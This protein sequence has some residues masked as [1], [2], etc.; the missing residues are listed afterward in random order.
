MFPVP[1]GMDRTASR[2]PRARSCVP[3]AHGDRPVAYGGRGSAKSCS[4]CPRGWTVVGRLVAAHDRVFPVPTG[5]DRSGRACRPTGASCPRAHG[6]GL[7]GWQYC[8]PPG[9]SSLCSR[10]WTAARPQPVRHHESVPR[11][12]GDGPELPDGPPATR[13]AS[14]L[15]PTKYNTRP[16]LNR[17]R[18]RAGQAS[19]MTQPATASRQTFMTTIVPS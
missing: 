9:H 13:T 17:Q 12:H 14:F 16:S 8:H 11:V 2:R 18:R 19:D 3:R 4:P 5:M 7:C 6:D 10:G 1:T 15:S